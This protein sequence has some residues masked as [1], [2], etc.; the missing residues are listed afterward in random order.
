M[1]I[2]DYYVASDAMGSVTAILDEDG[3]VIERRSYDAFG[4]MTCMAPDGTQVTESP[5]GVD[6]GFQGQIRDDVT[7][8]YQ[9]G[10]R[11]HNPALG[12]WVNRDYLSVNAGGDIYRYC[13][14]RPNSS[15]DYYGLKE[16]FNDGWGKEEYTHNRKP[17]HVKHNKS[18]PIKTDQKGKI[19]PYQSTRLRK[20]CLKKCPE[21]L[22]PRDERYKTALDDPLAWIH[23]L[24]AE[25][26]LSSPFQ[27]SPILPS[28]IYVNT[29]TGEFHWYGNYGGPGWT[30]GAIDSGSFLP[31]E[32]V[33]GGSAPPPID[34]QDHCYYYHDIDHKLCA[35][36][37]CTQQALNDCIAEADAALSLC[38]LESLFSI[39]E[40]GRK[41]ALFSSFVFWASA[42]KHHYQ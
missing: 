5:T 34:A 13:G 21:K 22:G 36:R 35:T 10:F 14:N 2:T 30:N 37:S 24:I 33:G 19:L 11:W 3:N 28:P 26:I 31:F 15:T 12:R 1:P 16:L 7:G 4:E 17:K 29:S 39:G 8:L 20:T 32:D 18:Q 23:D 6:V 40:K 27:F 42:V 41:R 25:D 38:L 9:M